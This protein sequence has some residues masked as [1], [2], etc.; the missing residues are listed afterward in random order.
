MNDAEVQAQRHMAIADTLERASAL[1][2]ATDEYLLVAERFPS[3]SVYAIAVRKVGLLLGSPANLAA[4]DSASLFWLNKYL[5]LTESPEEKQFVGM[6]IGMVDRMSAL[7]DSLERQAA[8]IDSLSAITRKQ[9][10]ETATRTRRLQELEAE[11]QQVSTEL[12]KLKE[13]DVRISKSRGKN[14]P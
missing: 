14:K 12:R 10:S 8:A 7:R 5:T 2:K 11:L 4:N 3:T 1:K 13:I 9:A 6:Y